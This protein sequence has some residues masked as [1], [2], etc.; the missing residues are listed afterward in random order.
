MIRSITF[1]IVLGAS[2]G[3]CAPT[4]DVRLRA[5]ANS[6][7]T[8][9]ARGAYGVGHIERTFRIR[10]DA[11]AT[12]DVFF[13]LDADDSVVAGAFPAA[14]FVQGGLVTADRYGWFGEHIASR[15]AVAVLPHHSGDLAFFDQ[16]NATDCYDAVRNATRT[17]G[18]VL[19]GTMNDGP[20]MIAGHSLGGVVAAK[21]WLAQPSVFAQLALMASI[22]DP[23]DDVSVRDGLV[24]SVGGK[25]DKRIAP[26]AVFDGAR[27][28]ADAIVAVV[29]GMNHYQF[30]DDATDSELASD[31]K[32]T[33][34]IN[35]TRAD[36]MFLVDAAFEQ[37]RTG[38]V[39]S[40]LRDS[41]AWP[42]GLSEGQ[43]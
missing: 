5:D 37:L 41:S 35:D 17:P 27:P 33:I 8:L 6:D 26:P 13:A 28:F 4:Y 42:D 40:Q 20:A 22:P 34:A 9:G 30:T 24:I 25:N 43:P 21:A 16:G 10:G 2:A 1:A 23:A 15:G 14:V 3:G 31:G 18:D 11:S 7:G 39:S 38:A 29:D 12:A 32:A 36:A 19:Q